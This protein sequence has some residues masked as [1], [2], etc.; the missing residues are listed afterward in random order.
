MSVARRTQNKYFKDSCLTE[1][2]TSDYCSYNIHAATVPPH[3]D[4][5]DDSTYVNATIHTPK[6]GGKKQEV[7]WQVA[8]LMPYPTWVMLHVWSKM[9]LYV[10]SLLLCYAAEL[11]KDFKCFLDRS[12]MNCSWIPVNRSLNLTIAYRWELQQSKR[13]TVCLHTCAL[14]ISFE[15][16]IQSLSA[17]NLMFNRHHRNGHK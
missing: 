4:G 15:F 5:W 11:V 6:P 12:G 17:F 16:I 13:L 10:T 2:A 1:E 7:K 3:C 8:V 14:Y 9:S